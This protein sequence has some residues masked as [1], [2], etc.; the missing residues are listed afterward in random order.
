MPLPAD[1]PE[2][3]STALPA[4]TCAVLCLAT[5]DGGARRLTIGTADAATRFRFG[6]AT[7]LLTALVAC[8]LAGEGRLTLD[9]PLSPSTSV[10]LRH[11][12]THT[13]GLPD[14]PLPALV[15]PSAVLAS[16]WL[17]PGVVFSYANLGFAVAGVWLAQLTGQPLRELVQRYVLTPYGMSTAVLDEGPTAAA[18]GLTGTAEDAGR[19]LTGLL[20]HPARLASLLEIT[21]AVPSRPAMVAGLG[22]FSRQRNGVRLVEHE[23]FTGDEACVVCLVPEE[24]WG[25]ALLT[26]AWPQPLRWTLERLEAAWFGPSPVTADVKPRRI[27]HAEQACYVGEYV[28]DSRRLRIVGGAD[29]LHLERWGVRVPLVQYAPHHLAVAV[30]LP[31]KPSDVMVVMDDTGQAMC[32][33]PFGSLRALRRVVSQPWVRSG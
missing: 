27:L 32:L 26:K 8:A 5:A 12:L 7:K 11:L 10:T 25:Y 9:A 30:P 14:A 16:V 19:L 1:W 28:N 6:S 15:D 17:P 29:T 21:V 22:C 31:N 4:E 33:Y 3:F 20:R 23:G 18:G 13:A 2:V 24:G